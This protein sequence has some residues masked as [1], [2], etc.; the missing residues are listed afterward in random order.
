[1]GSY[2]G[3]KGFKR[4]IFF[5]YKID[6]PVGQIYR[7]LSTQSDYLEQVLVKRK[8]K[9]RKYNIHG[10]C[11]LMQGDLAFMFECNGYIAYLCVID[12][13]SRRISCRAIKTKSSKVVL[14][15]LEDIFKELGIPVE[16]ETDQGR[17][18]PAGMPPVKSLNVCLL[19]TGGEF[20]SGIARA[21]YKQHNIIYRE[22]MDPH[23]ASVA[24]D[25]IYLTKLRMFRL[26]FKKLKK[27]NYKV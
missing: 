6:V 7:V 19:S 5:K 24:E 3:A 16:F 14:E 27:I 8:I 21:Y 1:M 18:P 15:K 26:A 13:F 12:V 2:Q 10:S 25:A 11:Q 23:K 9:T 4:D 17:I 22:K 20:N